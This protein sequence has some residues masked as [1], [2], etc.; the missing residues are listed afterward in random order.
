MCRQALLLS[1]V[2][3]L[4]CP[5]T[6]AADDQRARYDAAI[7]RELKRFETETGIKAPC[8]MPQPSGGAK[9]VLLRASADSLST[10]TIGSQDVATRTGA[11]VVDAGEEPLYLIVVGHTPTIWR[12]SGATGRIERLVMA[13]LNTGPNRGVPGEI[14][15]IGATGIAG[16]R[17]TFLRHPHCLHLFEPSTTWIDSV[18]RVLKREIGRENVRRADFGFS[19]VSEVSVPSFAYGPPRRGIPMVWYSRKNS[20]MMVTGDSASQITIKG[21][22]DLDEE[23]R[24]FAPG[25][26]TKVDAQ[27]VVASRP[28][29][30]YAVLPQ[31]AGL[32]QLMQS[33][34]I[35]RDDEGDFVIER[36]IRLPA[37]LNG[38]HK[39]RLRRGVPA[40]DGDPGH[41]CVLVEETGTAL[42]G[43]R[44]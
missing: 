43:S 38:G 42:S 39:F 27:A 33:G 40:P 16:D 17:V 22:N 4:G 32:I 20:A 44:C 26:V 37:E 23:F 11:I 7:E 29:E 12:V 41:V 28:A 10:V 34:A 6:A 14:P 25:G 8:A 36:K 1:I 19:G 5:V 21:R 3:A 35:S 9:V 30:P 31:Q 2:M 15:L 24:I 13:S 18:D